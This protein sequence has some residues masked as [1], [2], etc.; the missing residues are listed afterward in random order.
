MID[1]K[2]Q[3]DLLRQAVQDH[4][5]GIPMSKR[6]LSLAAA[7]RKTATIEAPEVKGCGGDPGCPLPLPC[8]QYD[9]GAWW[10]PLNKS[11]W[12]RCPGCPD[13]QPKA[14]PKTLGLLV[15]PEVADVVPMPDLNFQD[16]WGHVAKLTDRINEMGEGK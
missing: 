16:L 14:D 10:N 15:M 9:D 13:C 5:D 2:A 4:L 12:R 1:Y 3:R 7:M 6:L 11:F 8:T